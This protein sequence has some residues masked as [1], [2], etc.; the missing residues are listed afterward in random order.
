MGQTKIIPIKCNDI[1]TYNMSI[2]DV[3]DYVTRDKIK[4]LTKDETD[5]FNEEQGLISALNYIEKDKKGNT[6]IYKTITSTFNC[7]SNNTI[8][9]FAFIRNLYRD[10]NK[11][12]KNGTENIAYHLEQ[13]FF[14]KLDPEISNEIG[15]KLVEELFPN[16]QCV[17]STHCN[18]DHT[19]NHIVINAWDLNGKKYHNCIQTY[20]DIRKKS[21]EL[22]REYGLMVNLET[23]QQRLVFFKDENGKMRFYE[24]TERK[25]KLKT[26]ADTEQGKKDNLYHKTLKT[27]IKD[28]IDELLPY[29]ESYEDLLES[30]KVIGYE[31]KDKTV[32]GEYLKHIAF[33]SPMQQKFTRDSSLGE[34]YTRENLT[35]KIKELQ[36]DNG[37]TEP[38]KIRPHREDETINQDYDNITINQINSKYKNGNIERPAIETDI[39]NDVKLL[40]QDWNAKYKAAVKFHKAASNSVSF[41]NK[42]QQYLYNCINDNLQTL[43]FIESHNIVSAGQLKLEKKQLYNQRDKVKISLQ[44]IK[45]SLE[46]ANEII[47]VVDRFN[48]LKQ[49]VETNKDN[50]NYRNFEMDN[51]IALI[52]NYENYLSKTKYTTAE[53]QNELK[54]KVEEWNNRFTSLEAA[55][56]QIDSSI[57]KYDQ[58]IRTINRIEN[59]SME[60]EEK[61]EDEYER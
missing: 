13:S 8:Q 34:D 30:L 7:S 40:N 28:D 55:V 20:R 22:C 45:N 43:S 60:K 49:S 14:E 26:Y 9:D 61:K 12:N 5:N 27:I 3:I 58:S 42:H 53:S 19:H 57:V 37:R 6:I 46:K 18:T 54:I 24:P 35:A 50:L 31:I 52:E 51:E 32:N 23:E 2:S 29:A 17:I 11:A 4:K 10:E 44:Q 25:E 38:I 36:K 56:R 47:V 15:L 41:A 33:K 16:H 39:I 48:E 1:R 59:A 21:D